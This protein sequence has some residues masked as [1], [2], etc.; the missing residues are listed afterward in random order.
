MI[1]ICAFKKKGKER[2]EKKPQLDGQW[3]VLSLVTLGRFQASWALEG[4]KLG[5]PWNVPC[6]VAFGR[7]R[8][9]RRRNILFISFHFSPQKILFNFFFY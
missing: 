5:G 3:K 8:K 7:R 2:G 6:L 4:S 1:Q 9:M